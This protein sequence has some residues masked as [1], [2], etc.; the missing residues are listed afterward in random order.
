MSKLT[1][2][3]I[4]I[5]GASSG[6]GLELAQRY[7]RDGNR[8]AIS[9]RSEDKLRDIAEA[10]ARLHPYPLDVTDNDKVLET[11]A[12]IR[13]GV[14]EI[15]VA[16]LCAAVWHMTDVIDLTVDQ[17]RQ[18]LEINVLGVY[19]AVLALLPAM[20]ARGEGHIVIVAS[21]AGY[22]G[23]PKSG[24]Y[25]PTKAALINLAE[26]LNAELHQF[27]I[28]VSVVNPGFVDTPMTADNPF[29]MPGMVS[30]ERAA[31]EIMA[32]VAK[33]KFEITFPCLFAMAMKLLRALPDP[34]YFWVLR[35][36]MVEERSA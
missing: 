24:A 4:W 36:F 14:G 22:R 33:G 35:R 19:Q 32:G 15:D 27:G 3:T 18:A 29:P 7:A 23:L 20:R 1:D 17:A 10:A 11:V 28:R 6:I 30:A 21:V 16:I 13:D 26:T 25:G 12:G 5:V 2:K 34:V 9:A 31:R 8:V